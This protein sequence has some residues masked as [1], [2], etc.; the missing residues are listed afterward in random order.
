MVKIIKHIPLGATVWYTVDKVKG[1]D[2]IG[3][4]LAGSPE[5]PTPVFSTGLCEDLI[6]V[7]IECIKAEKDHASRLQE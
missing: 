7:I 2:Y 6:S 5:N 1:G 4:V 3:Y